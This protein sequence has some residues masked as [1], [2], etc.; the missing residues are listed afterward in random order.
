V[1]IGNRLFHNFEGIAYGPMSLRE[2]LIKSCDTVFY[3]LAVKDWQRDGGLRPAPGRPKEIFA[4][5]ARAYGFGTPTGVDLPTEAAGRIPD[6][7]WKKDFW[8]ERKADYCAGARNAKFDALHRRADAEFCHYGYLYQPGDAANFAIGQGDVLV[9]PLQLAAAYGALATGT[10]HRPQVGAAVVSPD[11]TVTWRNSPRVMRRLPVA[12]ATLRYIRSAL[13][14]VP[15]PG[16]TAYSAFAGWPQDR[17]PVA[18]KTGTAEV[19]L[20][21]TG[22]QD[23]SWF[24]SFAPAGHPRFVVVTM[25]E[26][27][28]GHYTAQ[29]ARNIYAGIFGVGR[30]AIFPGGNIPATLPGAGAGAMVGAR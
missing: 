19:G 12:P 21:K 8:Q 7:Q 9:T 3:P 15:E 16:G 2:A 20:S 26:E 10:L 5:T 29:I 22:R 28:G 18:A 1:T 24:A 23:T 17:I 30:A 11:G 27:V 14:G 6:R 13:R 4:K 25:L